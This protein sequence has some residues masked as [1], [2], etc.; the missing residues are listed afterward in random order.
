MNTFQIFFKDHNGYDGYS[1]I[2]RQD[3][4]MELYQSHP[5][6]AVAFRPVTTEKWLQDLVMAMEAHGIAF[7]PWTTKERERRG[8]S[9][10]L[11]IDP[12]V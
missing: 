1:W 12:Q 11:S 4:C 6:K 7:I 3:D 5:T 10:D 2:A 8:W 9:S